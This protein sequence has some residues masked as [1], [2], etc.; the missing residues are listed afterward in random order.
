MKKNDIADR[1]TFATLLRAG[2]LTCFW[3]GCDR[4]ATDWHN[5]LASDYT[6]WAALCG[7]HHTQ[8]HGIAMAKT[9]LALAA[10]M[11][12]N[13]GKVKR[14]LENQIR[15]CRRLHIP[16]P[17]LDIALAT[18]EADEQRYRK[19]L[20][21]LVQED[22]LWPILQQVPG[23]GPTSAG[24]LLA[25]L[26]PF[27][28]S[29]R[30]QYKWLGFAPKDVL[31]NGGQAYHHGRRWLISQALYQPIATGKLAPDLKEKFAQEAVAK[32]Y[33]RLENGKYHGHVSYCF[34]RI[35]KELIK[36]LWLEERK[37]KGLPLPKPHPAAGPVYD[38]A[39]G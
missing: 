29:I 32:G 2:K 20:G 22:P 23:I 11:Y 24:L 39:R 27:R 35:A 6:L 14:I 34:Y 7:H 25:A 21:E 33:A 16:P 10:T 8:L 37:Q 15:A 26:R 1:T 31:G 12:L 5:H 17:D 9:D 38:F 3:E 36:W 30:G 18:L 28:D 19:A 4:P 13:I